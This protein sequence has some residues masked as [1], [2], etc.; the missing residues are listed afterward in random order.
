M[1]PKPQTFEEACE[2]RG[3]NPVTILPDGSGQPEWLAKYNIAN[4]KRLIIAEAIREGKTVP[5][6]EWRWFGV[7]T[8]KPSSFG[9]SSSCTLY[10]D[11]HSIVGLRLEFF[12]K[13]QSDYFN[14]NF[15]ELHRAVMLAD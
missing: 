3:Y 1:F 9:F 5:V 4:T 8:L 15:T 12:S 6:G 11:S 10:G 14:S 13:E 7:F 2:M